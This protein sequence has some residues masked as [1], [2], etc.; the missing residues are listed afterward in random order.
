MENGNFLSLRFFFFFS[1]LF[2]KR[3]IVVLS[4]GPSAFA[5]AKSGK[6]KFNSCPVE[7]LNNEINRFETNRFLRGS[8]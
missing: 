7:K 2:F 8:N 5:E 4:F 6:C 1:F 3:N